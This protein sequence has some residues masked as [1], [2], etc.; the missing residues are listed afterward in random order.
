MCIR[1]SRPSWDADLVGMPDQ[2]PTDLVGMPGRSP[3]DLFGM[4]GQSRTDLVDSSRSVP[5]HRLQVQP[6]PGLDWAK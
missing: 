3:T 2:S 1:D 6:T 4:P 5:I